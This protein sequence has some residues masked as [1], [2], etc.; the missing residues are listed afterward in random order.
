[1]NYLAHAHL[2]F[3]D[4]D[5][6]VGNMISDYVK[7]RKKFDLPEGI[8]NGITLH[9]LI[10]EFTDHH[11]ATAAAKQ[12]FRPFYRLYSGAVVDVIYD[13]FLANDKNEFTPKSLSIFTKSVYATLQANFSV[14]PESFQKILPHMQ[15]YD[16]LFNYIHMWGIERSLAGLVRRSKYLTD[17]MPAFTIFNDSYE[18]LQQCY[19]RFFKDVK[20]FAATQLST[21]QHQ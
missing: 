3:G 15:L 2:S 6:L 17:H 5:I 13:H 21:L 10:D 19:Y 12:F 14:L 9:R 11:P 16:W 4:T 1:M 7:G 8:Q 18:E 20:A